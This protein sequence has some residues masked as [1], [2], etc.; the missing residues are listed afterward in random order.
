MTSSADSAAIE[1]RDLRVDYGDFIAVNE[2]SLSVPGGEVF[3][4]V[5]PNGAGKTS[6]FKVLATL[7]EPTYGEVRLA[8]IDAPEKAQPFGNASRKHLA[9]MVAGKEVRV[10]TSKKDRYGRVLG[11]VW[12]QP[13]NCPGC[14][15]TLNA[16]LAQI[17]AGMA[18]WYEYYARDQ[19]PED[20]EHRTARRIEGVENAVDIV[21]LA[22]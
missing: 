16:N 6:T 2:V 12:V 9:S 15:K 17:Q 3:G 7:M 21:I 20:R 4:I 13:R 8:G 19:P 11:K 14:G 10:E 22:S 1:I 18:W 5:G